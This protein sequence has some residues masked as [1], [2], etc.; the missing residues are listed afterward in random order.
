MKQPTPFSHRPG[1]KIATV[2]CRQPQTPSA[3][4]P[5]NVITLI[6]TQNGFQR[7]TDFEKSWRFTLK[8]SL[9]QFIALAPSGEWASSKA[10]GV[11]PDGGPCAHAYLGTFRDYRRLRRAIA[12]PRLRPWSGLPYEASNGDERRHPRCLRGVHRCTSSIVSASESRPT[13]ACWA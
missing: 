10:V 4:V 5:A 6:R 9:V 2:V 12:R 1:P 3:R 7:S 13:E 11:A 8:P